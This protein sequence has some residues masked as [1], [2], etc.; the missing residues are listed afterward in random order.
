[1]IGFLFRPNVGNGVVVQPR[2]EHAAFF[3]YGRP[4]QRSHPVGQFAA[5]RILTRFSTI[6]AGRCSR[7]TTL[8]L[9]ETVA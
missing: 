3:S 1:M 9:Y 6:A 4:W 8:W 7:A 2:V 5:C